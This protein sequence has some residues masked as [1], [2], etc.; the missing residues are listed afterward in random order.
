MNTETAQALKDLNAELSRLDAV[1][2]TSED[3][4]HAR[5][6]AAFYLGRTAFSG[7]LNVIVFGGIEDLGRLRDAVEGELDAINA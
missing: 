3:P 2:H 5:V 7:C 6:R 4:A 1:L